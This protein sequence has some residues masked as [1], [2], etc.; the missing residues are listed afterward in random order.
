MNTEKNICKN[1]NTENLQT[2]NFCLGCG[3]KLGGVSI[4]KTPK[5]TECNTQNA[6]NKNNKKN[7]KKNKNNSEKNNISEEFIVMQEYLEKNPI[8]NF[9]KGFLITG[10]LVFAIFILFNKN[11][12][13]VAWNILYDGML[14]LDTNNITP[15]IIYF[16]LA[17][18]FLA[19]LMPIIVPIKYRC[20]T[21]IPLNELTD[22]ARSRLL[23]SIE[24]NLN[25]PEAKYIF[26][27][28][29]TDNTTVLCIIAKFGMYSLSINEEDCTLEILSYA[30]EESFKTLET[31]DQDNFIKNFGVKNNSFLI[32]R[33]HLYNHINIFLGNQ[34]NVN[35]E[36]LNKK[37]FNSIIFSIIP[38]SSGIL[39]M[40]I[41]IIFQGILLFDSDIGDIHT[42]RMCAFKEYNSEKEIGEVFFETLDKRKWYKDNN[43]VYFEGELSL[44]NERPMNIIMRFSVDSDFSL[45]SVT[46]YMTI[47]SIKINGTDFNRKEDYF[48]EAV[49]YI[50]AVNNDTVRSLNYDLYDII[51]TKTSNS[52]KLNTETTTE[53]NIKETQTKQELSNISMDE[54]F[55]IALNW[56]Y[57]TPYAHGGYFSSYD[58]LQVLDGY[59]GEYYVFQASYYRLS[60]IVIYVSKQNGDLLFELLDS[61][62][63]LYLEIITY[64]TLVKSLSADDYFTLYELSIDLDT[65]QTL[66]SDEVRKSNSNREL[67]DMYTNTD[68]EKANVV[69]YGEA[70]ILEAKDKSSGQISNV[71]IV[72]D[73]GEVINVNLV[74]ETTYDPKWMGYSMN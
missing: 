3:N 41:V 40:G 65:L 14:I 31:L 21:I 26:K 8:F 29:K 68:Y 55:N 15:I 60:E 59:S 47:E 42:I 10:F 73:T 9:K 49:S 34:T 36:K 50:Y 51:E 48:S 57:C 52:S 71:A 1:C 69:D 39:F 12:K 23:D 62:N 17:M 30:S 72:L 25:F 28:T 43:N 5:T 24:S 44:G 58:E 63:P 13:F 4:A 67:I 54:A 6:E 16:L 70:L 33:K 27:T 37:Y 18:L 61:H 38:I 46:T 20:K 56:F 32:E 2:S 35:V 19:I 7:N 66:V 11:T 74:G 64:E 22:L 53:T 45:K